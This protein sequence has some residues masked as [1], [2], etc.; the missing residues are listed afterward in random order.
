MATLFII[1]TPIG[2][3]SDMTYR[4][5][6]ILSNLDVL[7][8]EDTRHTRNIFQR[9]ALEAPHTIFSYH[10]YNESNSGRRILKFLESGKSVGL[11]S[12]AGYPGISD[13]G[14]RIIVDA[15]EQG[16]TIEVIPGASAVPIALLLSGLPTSSYTFKGF[17]PK[18]SGRR[19]TFLML[20]KEMPHTL[21]F[22]ESPQRLAEFLSD[23]L[24]VYGNR[25]AAVCIELTKMFQ[26]VHR[27]FLSG[28]H[29]Y[30][31]ANPVKGEIVVVIAG[32]NTKFLKN[33]NKE[34]EEE[35]QTQGSGVDHGHDD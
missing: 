24:A 13:P 20:D 6:E 14:Y 22:Y 15:I 1:A 11:C 35:Q 26:Q 4:G 23:A 33:E 9:Y 10:S 27:D 19:K 2:N 7:A 32:N 21:L 3:L 18:K 34:E 28:L 16:H 29:K 17:G 5:I 30:F 12:N 31:S 8:C 25:K